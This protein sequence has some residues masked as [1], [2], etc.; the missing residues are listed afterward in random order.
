MG[1]TSFNRRRREL[2]A[3][4]AKQNAEATKKPLLTPEQSKAKAA[5]LLS[6]AMAAAGVDKKSEN[7]PTNPAPAA[8][9]QVKGNKAN[10]KSKEAKSKSGG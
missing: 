7:S 5:E 8:A 6:K 3:K 1:L 4:K 10:G 2:A 9:A